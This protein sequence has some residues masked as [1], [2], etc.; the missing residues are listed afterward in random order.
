MRR[1]SASRATP[2]GK[3]SPC[4]IAGGMCLSFF[5]FFGTEVGG[6]GGAP[7]P[8]ASEPKTSRP[9]SGEPA[10]PRDRTGR[11]RKF[12]ES[13]VFTQ[14]FSYGKRPIRRDYRRA[15][16][17]SIRILRVFT[18]ILRILDRPAKQVVAADVAAIGPQKYGRV[19]SAPRFIRTDDAYLATADSS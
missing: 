17:N 8:D 3:A 10:L 14:S 12:G 16:P 15:H 13:R 19:D 4:E 5:G 11:P 1:E 7:G 2:E 6:T 18:D 9:C